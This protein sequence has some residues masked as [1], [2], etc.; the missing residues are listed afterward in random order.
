MNGTKYEV[1]IF[2]YTNFNHDIVQGFFYVSTE[3]KFSE[4]KYVKSL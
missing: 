3:S 2:W 4:N 1:H